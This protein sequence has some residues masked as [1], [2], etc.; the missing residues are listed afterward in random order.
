[1]LNWQ[2][3]TNKKPAAQKQLFMELNTEEKKIY[4][5]LKGKD[6][7][8]LDVIAI[9]CELP[10]FKVAGILLTIELKGLIRPLP[11]KLFELI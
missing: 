10:I 6:A 1:M 3:E 9:H 11:G 8:L 5:F 4:N 7:Q 2:L